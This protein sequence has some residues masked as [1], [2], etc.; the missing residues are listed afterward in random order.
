MRPREERMFLK[1]TLQK[2]SPT[3]NLTLLP[4]R[5]V[6]S[7]PSKGDLQLQ[8]SPSYQWLTCF[9]CPTHTQA[10]I[11]SRMHAIKSIWGLVLGF[12]VLVQDEAF[13]SGKDPLGGSWLL[14]LGSQRTRDV[15]LSTPPPFHETV[16]V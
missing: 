3:Q 16:M 5:S 13:H 9:L 15:L 12:G 4:H 11:A 10:R 6:S 8:S 2:E 14:V 1:L 7:G